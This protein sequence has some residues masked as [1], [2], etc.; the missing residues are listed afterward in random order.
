MPRL[1]WSRNI[2][3]GSAQA[4]HLH[5]RGVRDF[6]EQDVHS[7]SSELAS[8]WQTVEPCTRDGLVSVVCSLSSPSGMKRD[9]PASLDPSAGMTATWRWRFVHLGI[10]EFFVA[11]AL[12]SRVL[13]E[14]DFSSPNAAV[15]TLGYHVSDKLHSRW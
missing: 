3:R 2:E 11:R 14:A 5:R 10:Q 13:A 6:D 9:T 1:F 12:A 4:W 8:V 15:E 7:I